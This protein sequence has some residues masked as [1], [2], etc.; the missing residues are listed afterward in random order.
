[1]ADQL[2]MTAIMQQL[3]LQTLQKTAI[4]LPFAQDIFLLET[5]IAG[6]R[7]YDIKNLSMPLQ[8]AYTLMLRREPDN[9]HDEL[10]IVVLTVTA[11]KLGYLPKFRN[12][13]L[14]R[15]MDAGK[16]LVAEVAQVKLGND[17]VPAYLS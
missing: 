6:L 4:A 13:V 16:S 2:P 12:T 10:A 7:Y 5:H 1:M 3:M 8:L 9:V 17:T 14:A 15:L 11:Q